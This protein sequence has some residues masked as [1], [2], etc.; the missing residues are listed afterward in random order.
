MIERKPH[1]FSL[2]SNKTNGLNLPKEDSSS[3]FSQHRNKTAA[4]TATSILKELG[5]NKSSENESVKSNVGNIGRTAEQKIYQTK[6]NQDQK[7]RIIKDFDGLKPESKN[8]HSRLKNEDKKKSEPSKV[9]FGL[10]ENLILFVIFC[11]L[12]IAGLA[13]VGGYLKIFDSSIFYKLTSKNLHH[14]EFEGEFKA[15][16]VENGYNR[17]PLL[18]VEGTIRNSLKNSYNVGKIQ[19]KASAFDSENRIIASHFA[20]AGNVLTD[21]QLEKFSPLDIKAMRHSEDLGILKSKGFTST[22]EKNLNTILQKQGIPFQLVFFKTVQNIKR[23][24]VQ[25]V[26]Y[27]RNNKILFIRSPELK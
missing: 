14:L 9:N 11:V 25:I 6:K 23:T 3:F 13:F 21:E 7:N 4:E 15:R 8:Y 16:Q 26:S 17:L 12:A 24:S 27:V 10:H 20:Y 5:I 18:I 19:L 2:N 22:Q 1:K